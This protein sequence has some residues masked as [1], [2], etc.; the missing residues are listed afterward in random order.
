MTVLDEPRAA[1]T[2][3]IASELPPETA[4]GP[5]QHRFRLGMRWKLLGAFGVGFTAVF[6]V[7]ALILLSW[8]TGEADRNLRETLSSVAVGGAETIDVDQLPDLISDIPTRDAIADALG[9]LYPTSSGLL[10]GTPM[11]EETSQLFPVDERFW[12]LVDPLVNIRRTNPEASPYL[13]AF[14]GNGELAYVA[15]W[16]ARGIPTPDDSPGAG[17]PYL[18]GVEDVG[19][20]ALPYM[21]AGLETTTEQPG[22]YTDEFGEWISVYTPVTN[23]SGEVVGGLG[24]DYYYTYVSEVR[25]QVLGTLLWVFVPSYVV[26]MGIVVWL[27]G[28]LTRRLG[29]LSNASR[30][31]AEGDYEVDLAG[32]TEG[33]FADEMTDLADVFRVMVAKVGIRER[34]LNKQVQVLKVEIDEQRRQQ[35]VNEIVDSDFFTALTSKAEKMRKSVR[36]KEAAEAETTDSSDAN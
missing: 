6:I 5:A 26:L 28:W 24:V 4:S 18:I 17:A 9:E 36:D 29:R 25:Q 13:Y 15:T 12:A 7:V 16:G 22:S 19:P 11:T 14:D 21:L 2:P 33:R 1:T 32:A 35:A 30:Q 27:S 10:S 8:F 3:D 34:T 23:S 31:V 20:E